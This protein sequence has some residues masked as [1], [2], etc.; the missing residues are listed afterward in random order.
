M[1]I[2]EFYNQNVKMLQENKIIAKLTLFQY[3]DEHED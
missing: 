1:Y 3:L 2:S